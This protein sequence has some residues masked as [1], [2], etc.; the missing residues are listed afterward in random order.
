M[1]TSVGAWCETLFGTL[2]SRK[3][4]AP[5]IPTLPTTIKPASSRFA[6]EIST[7]AGLPSVAMASASCSFASASNA[8]PGCFPACTR[9]SFAPSLDAS[10]A[11][12]SVAIAAV[13]ERSVPATIRSYT[14]LVLL[15]RPDRE[16]AARRGDELAALIDEVDVPDVDRSA[17]AYRLRDG[18]EHPVAAR[19]QVADVQ[20]GAD[21]ELLVRLAVHER[22]HR[23]RALGEHGRGSAVK[24]AHR[25]VD[26]G[27]DVHLEDDPV[28]RH[29]EG[30]DAQGLVD[31]VVVDQPRRGLFHGRDATGRSRLLSP[32]PG[33]CRARRPCVRACPRTSHD[34]RP[35]AAPRRSF[36]PRRTEPL[37]RTP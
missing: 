16:R 2:P 18:L 22:A 21:R 4:R 37:R 26:L 5:L 30:A 19:P 11:A 25:L 29:L 33:S 1:S 20:V 24:K 7:S 9:V 15:P 23:G 35:Q 14:R 13:L 8:S 31:R 27:P 28:G 34:R 3:R 10:S 36:R 17:L 6:S 12:R 32:A